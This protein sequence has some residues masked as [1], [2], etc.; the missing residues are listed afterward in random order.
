M[1]LKQIEK[2]EIYYKTVTYDC[3]YNKEYLKDNENYGKKVN[4]KDQSL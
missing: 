3:R 4:A 2:V 1:K